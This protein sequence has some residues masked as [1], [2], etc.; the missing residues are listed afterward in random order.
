MLRGD[1]AKDNDRN[2]ELGLHPFLGSERI[3]TYPQILYHS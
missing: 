3:M 2:Q 1:V